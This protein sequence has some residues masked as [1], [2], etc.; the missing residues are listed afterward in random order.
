MDSNDIARGIRILW[1]SKP[2]VIVLMVLG[3]AIFLF[4]VVDTWRH[5][6]RRKRPR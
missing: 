4:V 1:E 5:K 3:F 6:R 2:A